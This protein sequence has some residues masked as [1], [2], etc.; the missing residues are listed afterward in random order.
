MGVKTRHYLTKQFYLPLICLSLMISGA[1]YF[2][3][4]E[5]VRFRKL[6]ALLENLDNLEFSLVQLKGATIG[7]SAKE[8]SIQINLVEYALDKV[9]V[10]LSDFKNKSQQEEAFLR[11]LEEE[12]QQFSS[13]TGSAGNGARKIED[14]TS[15]LEK[16]LSE[17]TALI[18][19]LQDQ[20]KGVQKR[21]SF[22]FYGGLGGLSFLFL[23]VLSFFYFRVWKPLETL[24]R[25]AVALV[26]G[27]EVINPENK[28]FVLVAPILN[29][30]NQHQSHLHQLSQL[31]DQIGEG[32]FNQSPEE[33]EK[34]GTLGRSIGRMREKIKTSFQ[35]EEKRRWSN[36]G[37]ANF[38]SLVREHSHDLSLLCS[39]ILSQLIPYLGA[40]QGGVFL[41]E[42]SVK[43]VELHLKASYAWGKQRYHKNSY[44]IGEGLVG[45][46]ALDKEM[47]F[48]TDVPDDF[49]TIGSG[50]G[51]AKPR[52]ILILPLNAGE[53]LHGVLE[54]A[55]FELFEEHQISFL[56]R[57]CEILASAIA[58]ANGNQVTR[59]LLAKAEE[60]NLQMQAQEEELRQ[61]SEEMMSTQE[62]MMRKEAELSGLFASINYNMLTAEI[63]QE[64]CFS[65]LNE[66]LCSLLQAQ[67][68]D[69]Q[70]QSVCEVLL[71]PAWIKKDYEEFLNQLRKGA[72]RNV[73]CRLKQNEKVWLSASF[74]PVK[75]KEG[76]L[77]KI[78]LLAYD[79]SEKK[80]AEELFKKQAEEI[81]F[82]EEQLRIYTTELESL[83][84]SLESRLKEATAEMERQIQE[85]ESEKTKN[86]AILEG[87]VDG[88]I[89]FNES[90]QIEYF[91]KAAEDIW[92]ISRQD[93][94][95]KRIQ[96]FIPV[97]IM[98]VE[99]EILVY[100]SKNGGRKILD[101]RTEVPVSGKAGQEMEVL[102]TLTRV[103]VE[104]AFTFTAF[105]QKVAVELF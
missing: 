6:D 14:L 15:S 42:Q 7:M 36:E 104:G 12:H 10:Q 99:D 82:Q 86:G 55:S 89:S 54:L 51:S 92:E 98:V 62:A 27:K 76:K 25:H 81:R 71:V 29:S 87:C 24:A 9:N 84:A 65:H 70:G 13:W 59:G 68:K 80:E 64:G 1:F 22:T 43:E 26:E 28:N 102:L 45:Q 34:A 67:G 5:Q 37:L 93:A 90:G 40:N 49:I 8:P 38:S 60:A 100:Y 23:F 94:L 75:N 39:K 53:Q 19:G 3:W 35:D 16:T 61:N 41:L 48:L 63:D 73:E 57:L 101:A 91:N 4:Q 72:A 52:C 88:V 56:Q 69:Y 30:L 20:L 21:M 58:M 44:L 47:V 96:D 18:A 78:M 103:K 97:E 46:V 66:K 31:A 105:A 11:N 74:T 85:I 79:I 77:I 50:L 95:E 2:A 17:N 83:Q 32:K 33:F